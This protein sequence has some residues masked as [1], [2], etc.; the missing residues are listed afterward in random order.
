MKRPQVMSALS[1]KLTE[2]KLKKGQD[3]I[4]DEATVKALKLDK[5]YDGKVIKFGEFQTF[6]KGFYP[7]KEEKNTV[8]IS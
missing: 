8:S 7:T 6:L 1:N 5:S 4:L 2:L 3:T